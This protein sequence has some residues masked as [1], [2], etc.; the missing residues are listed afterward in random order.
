[1]ASV[2]NNEIGRGFSNIV[3]LGYED[4]NKVIDGTNPF[5]G[6]TLSTAGELPV[7]VIPVGGAVDMAAVY[8]ST[9]VASSAA[10]QSLNV[11]V[12]GS[13]ADLISGVSFGAVA[14]QYGGGSGFDS[15][16]A[17]TGSSLR[18]PIKSGTSE[19]TLVVE[20][21]G[22]SDLTAGEIHIGLNLVKF[23]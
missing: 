4:I 17:D 6:E 8:E 11:G 23:V 7:A 20:I 18:Q 2:S 3:T 9:A 5:T 19:T 12:N 21:T 16:T 14:I 13:T 10:D 1:M 22:T 15:G